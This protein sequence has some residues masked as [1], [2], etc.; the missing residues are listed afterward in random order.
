MT[1]DKWDLEVLLTLY[2]NNI[3][4]QEDIL[5]GLLWGVKLAQDMDP[6]SLLK[7]IRATRGELA[8]KKFKHASTM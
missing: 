8:Q 1:T 2:P 5:L 3:D 6:E 4:R 7:T